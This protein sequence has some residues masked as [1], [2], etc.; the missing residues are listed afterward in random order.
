MKRQ[1]L[2]NLG[3]LLLVLALAT[4][5]WWPENEPAPNLE[6]LTSLKPEQAKQL[7]IQ[8]PGKP[9]LSFK[10][11]DGIWWM[12]SPYHLPANPQRLHA[13][14]RILEAPII[15]HFPL[16]DQSLDQFG[17][18]QPIRMQIDN[19]RFDFGGI[20]PLR[21]LRYL[22]HDK[23]L[24]LLVDRFHQH[25]L[26][27]AEQLLDPALLPPGANIEAIKTPAYQLHHGDH[28]WQL[29]PANPALSGDDLSHRIKQ[30]RQLRSLNIR[31]M[32]ITA[33][34]A[35]GGVH[36]LIGEGRQL[37][38]QIHHDSQKRLWLVRPDLGLGYQLPAEIDLLQPLG[39][40]PHA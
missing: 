23:R 29:T 24:I 15:N 9:E 32:T 30:W 39:T 35:E 5:V 17:L 40:K 33:D 2:I 16:P 12:Q 37:D 10:H 4:L 31:P 22:S 8:R 27:P 26:A 1:L 11:R 18:D 6:R 20:E 14:S 38:F 34:A 13:L 3:L 21:K 7:S 25:L 19:Q 28:G 36:I